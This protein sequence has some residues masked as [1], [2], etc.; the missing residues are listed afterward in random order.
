MQKLINVQKYD[1]RDNSTTDLHNSNE[2]C[3]VFSIV[4][5]CC[6]QLCMIIVHI[7]QL[8]CIVHSYQHQASGHGITLAAGSKERDDSSFLALRKGHLQTSQNVLTCQH[9]AF[10]PC[11]IAEQFL[12]LGPVYAVCLAVRPIGCVLGQ[13]S[14][15]RS[16]T[17][18]T[19]TNKQT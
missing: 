15:Y 11:N 14:Y 19:R 17:L 18:V 4:H 9:F 8:L 12:S 7:M 13:Q 6:A 3:V 2:L 10:A 5:V 1:K 16:V